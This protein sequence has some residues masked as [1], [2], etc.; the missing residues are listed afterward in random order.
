METKELLFTKAQLCEA[1][2]YKTH[3]DIVSALLEDDK[4]YTFEQVDKVID[5]FLKGRVK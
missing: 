1:Q 4:K 5:K 3:I 2:K